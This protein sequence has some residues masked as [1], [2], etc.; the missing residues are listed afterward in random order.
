MSR[1]PDS[2]A[3]AGEAGSA[4]IEA[5]ISLALLAGILG[6]VYQVSAA[7]AARHRAVEAR[8]HALLVARSVLAS[9]GSAI[10]AV[11]GSRQGVDSGEAWRTE[12][13]RCGSNDSTAGILYCVTV[14]AGEPGAAPLVTLFSRR[15]GP[16]A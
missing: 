4:L 6:A 9:V 5:V 2:P 1:R 3:C 13:Q 10:P 15:L 14:S 11:S 8:R 16:R 12:T 7:S